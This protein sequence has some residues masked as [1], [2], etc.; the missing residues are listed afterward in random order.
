[1]NCLANHHA[2][3]ED[4]DQG[5]RVELKRSATEGS[6][7]GNVVQNPS[8][9]NPVCHDRIHAQRGG[10]GRSLE[11]FRLASRIFGQRGDGDVEA[12]QARKTAEDEERKQEVIGRGTDANRESTDSGRNAE[13]DLA[14]LVSMMTPTAREL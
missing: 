14:S 8:L 10:N 6:S 2:S 7:Q 4:E 5:N 13:G 1:M 12:G 3:M 11:V 9:V